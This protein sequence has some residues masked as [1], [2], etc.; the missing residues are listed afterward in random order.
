MD[1][2]KNVVGKNVKLQ[3]VECQNSTITK[4]PQLQNV[5]T[6]N[7]KKSTSTKDVK[8]GNILYCFTA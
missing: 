8:E 6:L 3:N 2:H 1:A 5:D 7:H 4:R